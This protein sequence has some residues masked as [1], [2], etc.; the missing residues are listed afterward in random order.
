MLA[1]LSRTPIELLSFVFDRHACR[2]EFTR[3]GCASL[4]RNSTDGALGLNVTANDLETLRRLPS[5]GFAWAARRE[6]LTRHPL[7]DIWIVGGGD[8][9]YFHAALGRA[10]AIV[11]QH[12]LSR[13]HRDHYVP[14]ADALAAEVRGH[15]GFVP[16]TIYHLWHGDLSRRKYRARHE[17]LAAHDFDPTAFLRCADSGAWAWA[18]VPPALPAAIDAYFR[19]RHVD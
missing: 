5:R 2:V 1:Y 12:R 14:L 9:A 19:E 4:L 11:S 13:R 3:P 17:I 8:N 10:H 16:G 6:F 7:F 18:Q 15:I